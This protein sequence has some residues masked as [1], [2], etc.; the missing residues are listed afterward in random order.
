[1]TTLGE[2]RKQRDFG[3]FLDE[4]LDA[5]RVTVT[6]TRDSDILTNTNWDVAVA[7]LTE[8]C[9][10]ES[11]AFEER[12]D[13]SDAEFTAGVASGWMIVRFGHWAVGW[14]EHILVAPGTPADDEMQEIESALEG[15]PVLD[16]DAFS[17][18]EYDATIENIRC[19]VR[20]YEKGL[21]EGWEG[22]VYSWLWDNMQLEVEPRDGGGGYPSR[23]AIDAALLALG[24]ITQEDIDG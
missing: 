21:P 16:E 7:R 14:I 3:C 15:Y 22:E 20:V 1:M 13:V 9:G 2:Y 24:Y 5:W 11:E 10:D 18:A 17:A 12:E 6:R 4:R 19:E 23:E 8:K